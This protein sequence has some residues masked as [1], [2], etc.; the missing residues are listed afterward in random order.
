[1]YN[2]QT[3]FFSQSNIKSNFYFHIIGEHSF[4]NKD[5]GREKEEDGNSFRKEEKMKA[6]KGRKKKKQREKVEEKGKG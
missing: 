2:V 5:K 6:K 4:A 1:M 3:V